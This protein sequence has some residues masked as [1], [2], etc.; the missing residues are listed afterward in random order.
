MAR[1]LRFGVKSL[2]TR[3]RVHAGRLLPELLAITEQ[4]RALAVLD[5]LAEDIH[6]GRELAR[7]GAVARA[8]VDAELGEVEVGDPDVDEEAVPAVEARFE[9]FFVL[10]LVVVFGVAGAVAASL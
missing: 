10:C 8:L 4:A 2:K 5:D 9:G 3:R 1:Q 7:L 6:V